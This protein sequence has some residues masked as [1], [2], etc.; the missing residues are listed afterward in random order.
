MAAA[1]ASAAASAASSTCWAS[2]ALASSINSSKSASPE[3]CGFGKRA[4]NSAGVN[5]SVLTGAHSVPVHTTVPPVIVVVISPTRVS[6]SSTSVPPAKLLTGG[7]TQGSMNGGMKPV[8]AHCGQSGF[9][10]W[11]SVM[12]V[13]IARCTVVGY[14]L[15][16]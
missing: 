2:Q 7:Q 1:A 6:A 8:P 16:V 10:V 12:D 4:A 14:T 13:S 15:V 5:A 9:G 3:R 11:V